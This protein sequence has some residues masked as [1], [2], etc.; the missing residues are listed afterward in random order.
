MK[1][2]APPF[3]SLYRLALQIS[4][5]GTGNLVAITSDDS[6]YILRFDRSAYDAALESGV[7]IGDEGVEDAFDV[8]AE[9]SDKYG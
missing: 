2:I 7:E 9:I 6:F 4:W 5:S 8:I 1:T 3:L